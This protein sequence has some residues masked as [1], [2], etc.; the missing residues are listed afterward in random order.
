MAELATIVE[1]GPDPA[2]GGV[3]RWRRVDLKRVVAQRFG[4]DFHE[5]YIGV[6]LAGWVS[7]MSARGPGPS[8]NCGV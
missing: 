7:R 5:R 8:D 6:L 2:V 3:V 1:T 4:I